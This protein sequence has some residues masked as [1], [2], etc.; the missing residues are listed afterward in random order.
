M[1]RVRSKDTGPEMRVRRLLHGLG[2]RYRLHD[3]SLPGCPDLVF[4][5]WGAVIFVHGCFWHSHEGCPSNRQPKS[6]RAYWASKRAGNVA[7]DRTNE[8]LLRRAGWK[9]LVIW[10]C[11]TFD[12][13]RLTSA[14]KRFLDRSKAGGPLRVRRRPCTHSAPERH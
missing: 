7:R 3:R 9:V 11:E 6:N 13:E 12:P 4:A 5:K 2:Y 8:R 10:E 1:S 14:V